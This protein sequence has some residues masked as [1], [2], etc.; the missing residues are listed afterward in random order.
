MAEKTRARDLKRMEESLETLTK[1]VS[2]LTNQQFQ[3]L[4]QQ[5]S[6]NSTYD[7]IANRYNQEFSDIRELIE[8]INLQH[9]ETMR[10]RQY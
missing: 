7:G 1:V 8:G 6:L 2:E 5:S 3:L 4:K 10:V 9:I